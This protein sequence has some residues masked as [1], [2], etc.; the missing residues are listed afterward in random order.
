MKAKR[1]YNFIKQDLTNRWQHYVNSHQEFETKSSECR[2]WLDDIQKKLE[3]C[4]D[5]SAGSQK[6]LET[7]LDMIQVSNI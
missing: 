2:H 4:S 5:L 3:Y 6:D 1:F 7:K